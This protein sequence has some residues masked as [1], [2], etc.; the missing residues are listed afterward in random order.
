[1][2]V[3]E[4]LLFMSTGVFISLAIDHFRKSDLV[5]EYKNQNR[6]IGEELKLVESERDKM[7]MEVRQRDE[8]LSIASHELKTPLTSML[9]KIQLILHNIRNVT[10]ANFSVQSLM[11]ML[12][13]AEVQ[14]KRLAKMIND[15]LNVS[16][17]TTGRLD[18]QKEN[19][20]LVQTVKGVIEEF[21]EKLTTGR[22]SINLK[23]EK[24]QIV[25]VDKLR[26]EQVITNIMSNAIKYGKSKP[27]DI[28][29][30]KMR[31]KAK[32]SIAD[33]GIGIYPEQQKRIFKLFERGTNGYEY[34]GLGVGLFIANQIILAHN[35]KIS[36]KSNPGHGSL[37][38]IELP[39]N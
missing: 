39:L 14:T 35:G 8:F 16:L 33:H 27:I 26:F 30:K 3:Y 38:T 9:L 28:E 34:K 12:V 29:V 13:T 11:E 20:D 4:S 21:S 25:Y 1:M 18:L 17:I 23:A 36:V 22:Y 19:T 2:R 6:I 31:E 32:I 10:L 7:K 15:L 5:N 24:S 37:F